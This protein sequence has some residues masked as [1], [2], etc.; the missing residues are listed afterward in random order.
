[1]KKHQSTSVIHTLHFKESYKSLIV[2]NYRSPDYIEDKREIEVRD[3]G[4]QA[5]T[6]HLLVFTSS[7]M[8]RYHGSRISKSCTTTS[9]FLR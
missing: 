2:D 9:G 4:L 5:K 1:M 8:Y 6:L 7:P 3:S